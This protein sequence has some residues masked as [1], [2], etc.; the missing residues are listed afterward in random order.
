MWANTFFN[1][2]GNSPNDGDTHD[3]NDDGDIPPCNLHSML[4]EF[5]GHS[6]IDQKEINY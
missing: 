3:D 5:A 4:H 2:P 6:A 1:Q